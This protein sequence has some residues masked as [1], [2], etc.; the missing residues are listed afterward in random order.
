MATSERIYS[1]P[2]RF[3]RLENLHIVLWLIKDLCWAML[4]KPLGIIMVFPTIA[5]ALLITYQTRK[6]KSELLHNLA[7]VCWII[8]NGYWMVTEFYFE[9]DSLRF[10]TAI[11]F[12]CGLVIIAYYY[13]DKLYLSGKTVEKD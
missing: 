11:P 7:V 10:Y 13:L 1:I 8:A 12:V 4:W 6:I 5:A 9:D 2:E 3:R